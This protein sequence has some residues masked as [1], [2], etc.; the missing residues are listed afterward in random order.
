MGTWINK[1]SHTHSLSLT[2]QT[3]THIPCHCYPPSLSPRNSGG[4]LWGS[5][6][7]PKQFSTANITT[8]NEE[9]GFPGGSVIKNLPAKQEMWVQ[10]SDQ[11]D[12]LEK[13]VTIHSNILV[14][15][16]LWTE[17]PGGLQSMGLRRVRHNWVTKHSTKFLL[18]ISKN[19][20]PVPGLSV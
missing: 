10:S 20:W 6:R 14:W 9:W 1:M 11:E 4:L 8:Q 12:Y 16:I 19:L 5:A 7:Q 15:E 18:V 17:E 13:E 2:T 3:H